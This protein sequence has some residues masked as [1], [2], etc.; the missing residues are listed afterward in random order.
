MTVDEAVEILWQGIQK[1]EYFPDA[2]KGALSLDDAYRAQLGVL[3]R[4]VAAGEVHSGW[5][6]AL[7][8]ES[9]RQSMGIDAPAFGY[10][11]ESGCYAK[12]EVFQHSTIL[13]PCIESELFIALSKRL[14]GPGVTREQVMDAVGSVTPAFEVVS[15]RGNLAADLPL[16]VADNIAQWGYVLGDTIAPYPNELDLANMTVEIKCNGQVEAHVRG[17]EALDD[18]L[19]SIAWLANQL[20]NYDRALES[21]HGVISGAFVKPLPIE[22][23]DRW[24][25]HFSSVGTISASFE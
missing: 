5:K 10:L 1:G 25:T 4:R 24:E 7:S 3:E 23:G 20:S 16:G 22:K 6:I 11:L 18:Q 13:N 12:N 21:G 15:M 8:G 2:L 14:Q 19:E 17:E 9:T